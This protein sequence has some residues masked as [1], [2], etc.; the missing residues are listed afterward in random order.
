MATFEV[1]NGRKR[2]TREARRWR[3]R[4]RPKYVPLKLPS[5]L[6][7]LRRSFGQKWNRGPRASHPQPSEQATVARRPLGEDPLFKTAPLQ[8]SSSSSSVAR[9]RGRRRAGRRRSP[10]IRTA[11][12]SAY[13]FGRLGHW[14]AWPARSSPTRPELRIESARPNF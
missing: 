14:P 2:W 9:D 13:L 11:R 10:L 4:S 12:S 7:R 8:V 5:R 3:R 6:L 1:T